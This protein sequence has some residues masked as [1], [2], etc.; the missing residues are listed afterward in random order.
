LSNALQPAQLLLC[1]AQGVSLLPLQSAGL[2]LAQAQPDLQVLAEPAVMA[3]AEQHFGS[4]ATLQT[5]SQRL[6]LASQSPWNLAQLEFSTTG[7]GR[8]R[9]RLAGVWQALARSPQWRPV[10]WGL[11]CLL[12]LQVLAL[13]ALAWQQRARLEEKKAAIQNILRQTFPEVQLVIDAPLQMQRAVNDL[14]LAR[15]AGGQASLAR[16]LSVLSPLESHGLRISAMQAAGQQ[17]QLSAAAPDPEVAAEV[18][19]LLEAQGLRGIWQGTQLT[20]T[21]KESR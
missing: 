2:A 11:L 17:L 8:W 4:R 18:L 7:S 1:T 13:N 10:R 19:G 3:L 5:H 20:V 14:A 21:P 15:G 16:V 12:L 9:K 6:L